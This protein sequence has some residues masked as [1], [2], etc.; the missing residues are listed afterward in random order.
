MEERILQLEDEVRQLKALFY[1]DRFETSTGFRN[2]IV[3]Y[4]A[5]IELSTGTGT[6]IGTSATQKVGFYGKTPVVQAGAISAPNTQGATYNQTDVQSIVN[7]VN[8][9]R[10]VLTNIGI[11]L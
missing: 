11:T 2:K 5:D 9:I 4:D 3:L 10:T 8:S 7:A 6:K 1:K